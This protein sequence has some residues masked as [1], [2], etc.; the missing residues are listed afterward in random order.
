MFCG[1]CQKACCKL[2]T[3]KPRVRMN[4]TQ[5]VFQTLMHTF[6][7]TQS[8]KQKILVKSKLQPISSILL[9]PYVLRAIPAYRPQIT[10][11][12]RTLGKHQLRVS[13]SFELIIGAYPPTH[14]RIWTRAFQVEDMSCEFPSRLISITRTRV[15]LLSYV[16]FPC[17]INLSTQHRWSTL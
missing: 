6:C 7:L 15:Q 3:F 17:S 11:F 13:L 1:V 10:W 12:H 9:F 8:T 14:P 16:Q 5:W 2:H 4:N